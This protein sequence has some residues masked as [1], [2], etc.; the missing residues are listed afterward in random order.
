MFID[1]LEKYIMSG[2]VIGNTSV[3]DTEERSNPTAGSNPAPIT[4]NNYSEVQ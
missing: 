2:G 3:F 4:K 1:L